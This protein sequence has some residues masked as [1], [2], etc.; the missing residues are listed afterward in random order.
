MVNWQAAAQN[1]MIN[2]DKYIS[3]AAQTNRAKNLNTTTDKNYSEPL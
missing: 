2:A 3:N 1:W